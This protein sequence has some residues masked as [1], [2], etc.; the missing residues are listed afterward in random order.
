M[1]STAVSGFNLFIVATLKNGYYIYI[2]QIDDSLTFKS[3]ALKYHPVSGAPV[4][5]DGTNNNHKT[6]VV[7]GSESYYLIVNF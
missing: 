6:L 7:P 5:V 1:T 3:N 2:Q 4:Y